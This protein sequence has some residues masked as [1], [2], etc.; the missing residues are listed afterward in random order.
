MV[1]ETVTVRSPPV[2]PILMFSSGMMSGTDELGGI[3][4]A[5]LL[6]AAV[7]VIEG[8]SGHVQR[9]IRGELPS[10]AL[11]APLVSMILIGLVPVLQLLHARGMRADLGD[12]EPALD[13]GVSPTPRS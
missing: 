7:L 10:I 11:R 1:S 6:V 2:P 9:V 8:L 12:L 3:L 5:S 13:P 4:I